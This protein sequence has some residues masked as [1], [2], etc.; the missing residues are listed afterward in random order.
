MKMADL[1]TSVRH[2]LRDDDDDGTDTGVELR[3][4]Q[5]HTP[6]ANRIADYLAAHG[7]GHH[8]EIAAA[9]GAD[10]RVIA[11]G[12]RLLCCQGRAR[13]VDMVELH[14]EGGMTKRRRTVPL[15]KLL[16]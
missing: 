14:P 16:P 1:P 7:Q 5:S 4:K 15:Y 3:P 12:L 10:E 9:L 8:V 13:A 11:K 2:R 6:R